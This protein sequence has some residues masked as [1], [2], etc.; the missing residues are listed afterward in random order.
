[1]NIA[2][3]ISYKDAVSILSSQGKFHINLGLER[4]RMLLNLLGNPHENLKVIHVAGTNGKGSTCAMLSSILNEAGYK[5]GLYTSPHLVEYTERIKIAGKDISTED[6]AELIF[7]ILEISKSNDIPATEF[8]ILT[9]LA[10]LYF[11][12]CKAD[13]VILETGLGGRLDATNVIEKPILTILT[14]IDLDHTDRLGNTIEDIAYEKAGIIKHNTPVITLKDNA[15][16]SIFNRIS[17]EK[18]SQLILADYSGFQN[19]YEQKENILYKGEDIYELPLLGL[20]QNK[21]LALVL[22]AVKCLIQQNIF[23]SK[24]AVK[25]GL[26]NVDWPGRMQYIKEKKLIL[27]G[28]HNPSGAILLKKSLDYYFPDKK[29]IWLYSSLN[30]KDFKSVIEHLFSYDDII[31]CT[32][33]SNTKSAVEPEIL[34]KTIK[35]QYPE[36]KIH[37]ADSVKYGILMSEQLKNNEFITIVAGSLY[38]VGQVLSIFFGE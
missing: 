26:K 16:C 15:G 9:A 31:I 21:N 1:M 5:T 7:E 19:A 30:T 6:F 3:R 38:T 27:D 17:K 4:I 23:I 8:E 13:F 37:I 10:F 11:F 25:S 36:Q 14:S 2:G 28:A 20:W 29:R 32:K 35:E 12:Q 33:P 24:R 34:A 22:E 18:N